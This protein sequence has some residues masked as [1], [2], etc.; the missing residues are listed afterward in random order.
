MSA[1]YIEFMAPLVYQNSRET[2][3]LWGHIGEVNACA[4][5]TPCNISIGGKI[6]IL[7]LSAACKRDE[8]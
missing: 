3:F 2:S 6:L 7:Q 1:Q 4:G 8:W 5:I